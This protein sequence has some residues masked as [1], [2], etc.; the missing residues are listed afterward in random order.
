MPGLGMGVECLESGAVELITH[1]FQW[2]GLR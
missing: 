1:E 2:Q